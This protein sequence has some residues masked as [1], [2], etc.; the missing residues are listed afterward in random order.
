MRGDRVPVVVLALLA[1]ARVAYVVLQPSADPTFERPMLDGAYY[2]AWARG[3][4]PFTGAYYLGPLYPWFLK[5][6]FLSATPWGIALVQQGMVVATAALAGLLARREADDAAGICAAA[7][8][9]LYHPALFFAARPLSEPL[10]ILLL[11]A[12]LW[13]FPAR[14]AA[15]GLLSGLATLARPAFL[16]IPMLWGGWLLFTRKRREGVLVL[17][18]A[19]L[20]ILPVTVRNFVA[21]G[22]VVPVTA[23]SG[24]V[25]WLGN[26]PGAVGVYTPVD[27]FSGALATQQREAMVLAGTTDPVEADRFFLRKAIAA[28]LADPAGSIVLLAKRVGLSLANAE[29]GLDY[30]PEL[31][32]NPARLLGIV[33]FGLILGFAVAGWRA[34]RPPLAL[35]LVGALAATVLF[36]VSSRHRL[37]IAMLACIPAGVGLAASRGNALLRRETLLVVLAFGLSA[38][39]PARE[40][41]RASNAAA[42]SNLAVAEKEA[43]RLESAEGM[44]RRAIEYDPS[45]AGPHYNLGVVLERAGRTGDAERAYRDA[46]ARDPGLTEAA[47]NLAGILVRSNRAGEAVG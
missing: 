29:H 6:T 3:E 13:A 36:Y 43:G 27:G 41:R 21:S 15:A 4:A 31:D 32:A 8:V 24:I 42:L 26:A 11:V 17:A 22:H 47:V 23:N 25:L 12:G 30:A 40:I 18:G 39:Y 44:L 10:G 37:P 5:L 7:F 28:R 16:P 46:L 45:V 34:I 2:L 19:A 14:P 33:P 9:L 20:A 38:V 35:A 1:A